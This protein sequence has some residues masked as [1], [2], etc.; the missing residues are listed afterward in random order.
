VND[1]AQ[2]F[3]F[4]QRLT[5]A[6]VPPLVALLLGA[7][8]RTLRYEDVVEPGAEPGKL[9]G[10]QIW[11]FWHRCL[12]P[13]ACYFNAHFFQHWPKPAMLISLSFDGELIARSVEL[14]GFPTARGSSSRAGGSGLM[15]LAKG[16]RRGQPAAFTADGPRGPVYKAKPGAVKLALVTG[17]PI[18]AVYAHPEKA[19][20]LRSW[21]RFLIPK[22]F[23]R[24]AISWTR[25]IEAPQ[26]DDPAVIEAK[27]QELEAALERARLN[28]E[29]HFGV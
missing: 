28:A 27:R 17:Y 19:W 11:C 4:G 5:L 3:S 9:P 12:I 29:R 16:L 22:P 18:G 8:R 2:R 1:S 24:V 23:S 6:I 10:L 13:S 25:Y 26:I 15:T 14:L 20:V 7:L 21:D